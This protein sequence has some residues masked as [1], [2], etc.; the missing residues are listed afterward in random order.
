MSPFNTALILML[1]HTP[2]IPNA[3]LDNIRAP[4]TLRKFNIIPIAAGIRVLP[5]PLNAP[6]DAISIAIKIE[7]VPKFLNILFLELL[8]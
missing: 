6:A 2:V 7:L 4:G 5:I 1:H 3:M 8:Q